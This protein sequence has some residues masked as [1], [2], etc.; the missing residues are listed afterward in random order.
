[1]YNLFNFLEDFGKTVT[2]LAFSG[3]VACVF[4][5][6][7]VYVPM[8]EESEPEPEKE[9]SELELFKSKYKKEFRLLKDEEIP[10]QI[11][12]NLSNESIE[13]VTPQGKVI[14]VYNHENNEF[15]FYAD[16]KEI[17]YEILEVV[18][19]KYVVINNCKR[20]YKVNYEDEDED[21]NSNQ[22]GSD[23]YSTSDSESNTSKSS[24]GETEEE[25]QDEE[26]DKERKES[27]SVFATFKPYNAPINETNME[28]MG[29]NIKKDINRYKY[30]GRLEDFNIKD[31]A[32]TT[33]NINFETFKKMFAS[34][35]IIT[36][37][38]KSS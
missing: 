34:N 12:I 2:C 13:E 21:E 5:C 27:K 14:M 19:R 38:K 31:D 37:D 36:N 29:Y 16:T 18:S 15:K 3:V 32:R 6:Y 23:S 30:V 9:K 8:I 33:V 11:K 1:M 7:Y 26:E 28:D 20:L 35:N 10:D 17:S 4:V 22:S 25:S 24:D